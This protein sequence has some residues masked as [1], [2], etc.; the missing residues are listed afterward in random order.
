MKLRFCACKNRYNRFCFLY[1][2]LSDT[3]ATTE[4]DAE[5]FILQNNIILAQSIR[6]LFY[7]SLCR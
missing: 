6:T 3:T 5:C 1:E 4:N 2:A 7:T